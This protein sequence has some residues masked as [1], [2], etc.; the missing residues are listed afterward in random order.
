MTYLHMAYVSET[1]STE[2]FSYAKSN[3]RS[4]PF[5][6]ILRRQRRSSPAESRP[7]GAAIAGTVIVD[8]STSAERKRQVGLQQRPPSPTASSP[9]PRAE[10]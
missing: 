6:G 1:I 8:S 2:G 9:P 5:D 10:D 4:G 7:T 3:Y